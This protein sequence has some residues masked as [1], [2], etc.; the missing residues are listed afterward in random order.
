MGAGLHGLLGGL[1]H[2][3]AEVKS[4]LLG[5]RVVGL[6]G[7]VGHS[8][9]EAEWANRQAG[10]RPDREGRRVS[11]FFSSVV[12]EKTNSNPKPKPNPKYESNTQ[13]ITLCEE[14]YLI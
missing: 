10:C 4:G 5:Q 9:E 2:L 8:R 13:A 1:G 12:L 3:L 6:V 7:V 11:L 14:H